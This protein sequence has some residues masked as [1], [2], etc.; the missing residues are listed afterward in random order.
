MVWPSGFVKKHQKETKEYLSNECLHQNRWP[1]LP[2]SLKGGVIID[3][4]HT[5]DI[6][7]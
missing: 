7:E 4:Q 6:A 1:L 3:L 2:L 5:K